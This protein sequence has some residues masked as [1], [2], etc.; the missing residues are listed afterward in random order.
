MLFAR[1]THTG[2]LLRMVFSEASYFRWE[3]ALFLNPGVTNQVSSCKWVWRSEERLWLL[4]EESSLIRSRDCTSKLA[5]SLD[6]NKSWEKE[7]IFNISL[8]QACFL[9]DERRSI[10]VD[11][12][13]R[14]T[15]EWGAHLFPHSRTHNRADF[16]L[17]RNCLEFYSSNRDPKAHKEVENEFDV[18]YMYSLIYCVEKHPTHCKETGKWIRTYW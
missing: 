12:Q 2:N 11:N 16:R 17:Q 7:R 3:S 15:H 4:A 14:K 6:V 9:S 10:V 8:S 5:S 13:K 18:L 1:K